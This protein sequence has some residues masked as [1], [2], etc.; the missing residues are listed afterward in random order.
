[1]EKAVNIARQSEE[2]KKQRA[3][4]RSKDNMMQMNVSSLNM[5][6]GCEIKTVKAHQC[7]LQS[8]SNNTPNAQS[9]KCED[10][11]TENT[12]ALPMMPSVIHVERKPTINVSAD[13]VGTNVSQ[14]L[15]Y[16]HTKCILLSC[17]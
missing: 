6:S 3:A 9:N 15:L 10:L 16:Y 2:I 14:G 13:K 12:G 5:S 7:T 11:L 17:K 8:Q 1:M 4:L